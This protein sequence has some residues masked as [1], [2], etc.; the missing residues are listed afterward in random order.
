MNQE[1]ARR[2][3]L[4][5][6][7]PAAA[8]VFGHLLGYLGPG[9]HPVEWPVLAEAVT[10]GALNAV[11]AVGI[12]LV[13]RSSRVINFAHSAFGV[14]A[15]NIFMLL[16]VVE[17]WS[18]WIALPLSVGAAALAGLL[19]E[20]TLV[21]RFANS[22]RLVLTVVTLAVGQVLAGLI[23]LLPRALGFYTLAA[24]TSEKDLQNLDPLPNDI[25]TS[26]FTRFQRS[27]F[28]VTFT[29]DH[30]FAVVVTAVV[31]IGVALFF[32]RSSYGIAIRGA[33]ENSDRAALLGVNT[34]T[35]S[36]IVWV[37]AASMSGLAAVLLLPAQGASLPTLAT[38][39]GAISLLR[40]LAAAVVGRMEDIA[41]TVSAA[42]AITVFERSVFWT[43]S[44]TAIVDAALLG[45]IIVVLI[46]QRSKL[47]RTEESA[48]T[49]WAATE[50]ARG[51]PAELA[52]LPAV[53]RGRRW[54]L[55]VLAIVLLGYPWV[56]SP[57]QTN[58]GGLYAIFGIVGVS[59]VVLTGWGGQISL[60][61]FG[62][63]AVGAV[64]GGTMTSEWSVP[65]LLAVPLASTVGAG[66]AVLLGLP[67]LRIRGLYLAVTTMAFAVVV[68]TVFLNDR[69]FDWLLPG[70]VNRPKLLFIDTEGERPYY[71]LCLVGL[72]L[73]V[74]V[75]QGLRRTRTG[76]VLIAMRDNERGAQSFGLNLVRVRLITFAI[77]GFLAAF[78]GVLYAHHQH[79]VQ[80]GAFAPEQSLQMFL[81]AVI[82]GLGS[83]SGVL[84]GA[85]YLGTAGIVIGGTAGELLTSG[86]G[87][88]LV[89]LYFPGGLGALAFGVRDSWLRRIA[90]R[91]H[92]VVPSLVGDQRAA[93]GDGARVVLRPKK[94]GNGQ[95]IEVPVH[96]ELPSRIGLAGA[97][98]AKPGWQG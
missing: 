20:I 15:A 19:I 57:S 64:V 29:G 87:V 81:M 55:A 1:R 79:G 36:T 43:Y 30:L 51:I 31:L 11:A 78:A 22:P 71:Y 69:F 17:G 54:T 28:P 9:H 66:V 95:P 13:Y 37:V 61:Q 32:R 8:V 96:Y 83:V 59:L 89:M 98:Q 58:L 42:I 38:G 65:F 68:T 93:D 25:A 77:S 88:I 82:G 56:M 4:L 6:G 70:T 18:W 62:F 3:A 44:Q 7:I 10:F 12:V 74:V 46:V 14:G 72:G 60:G 33:A 76:R 47:A 86:V 90:I 27:W 26:P 45:A 2:A 80:Q 21:R 49:S 16:T 50:E 39:I 75:A 35:L 23:G 48:T 85:L 34:S 84:L 40:A 97:S 91:D 67:A 94:D 24:G 41:L 63:V 52:K 73:A 92:I 5:I 53:R